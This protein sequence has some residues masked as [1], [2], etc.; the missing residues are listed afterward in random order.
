MS[1]SK[2]LPLLLCAAPLFPQATPTDQDTSDSTGYSGPS[3]L[4]RGGGPSSFSIPSIGFR[5]YIGV[6]GVYDSQLTG[7]SLQPDGS[8]ASR[9]SEGVELSYGVSGAKHWKDRSVLELTYHGDFRHYTQASYYDGTDQSLNLH[10][11]HPLTRHM[12]VD[13]GVS[14]GTYNYRFGSFGVYGYYDPLFTQT[15]TADLFDNRTIFL[16]ASGRLIYQKTARLSF[17]FGGAGFLVRRRSSALYGD[18]GYAATADVSYRLTRTVTIGADYSYTHFS[19]LRVFGTS[20][21]QTG[22]GDLSWAVSKNLSVAVRAGVFRAEN[23]LLQVVPVDPVVAAITG[24]TSGIRASYNITY[25]PTFSARLLR[26]FHSGSC[27]LSYSRGASAGNGV[28]LAS[29]EETAGGDCSYSAI[30]YWSLGVGAAYSSLT[31]LEQNIQS[32]RYVY[33]HA[34]VT[35]TLGKG[36][37]FVAQANELEDLTKYS[38]FRARRYSRIVIGFTY[39]PGERPLSL[40]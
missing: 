17:S 7:I 8:V 34:G 13:L 40:W 15:S 39:S 25:S 31:A 19:F 10:L 11:S 21:I 27:A 4:S 9:G 23:L 6:S 2:I 12:L 18:T 35:R 30:R 36:L 1:A 33:L 16:Q 32:Y 5:P 14:A 22:A 28:F 26:S 3:V 20:D 38:A 24:Q 29:R 37:V